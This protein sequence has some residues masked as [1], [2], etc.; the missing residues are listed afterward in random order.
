MKAHNPERL[1]NEVSK[2]WE[3]QSMRKAIQRLD[4]N[5][6]QIIY[7]RYFLELPVA[8]TAQVLDVAEGTVKS[9]LYRALGRLQGIIEREFS[10]L[11]DGY[12]T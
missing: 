7:L 6:Q 2:R 4:D 11:R 9:R 12:Q 1:E 5:D 8:E 3:S 10:A